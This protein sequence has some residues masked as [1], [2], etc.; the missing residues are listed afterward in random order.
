M[1]ICVLFLVF[2][3]C[4][5]AKSDPVNNIVDGHVGHIGEVLDYAHNNIVQT[6]DVMFLEGELKSCQMALID[7]KEAYSSVKE[8]YEAKISY[9][10]LMSSG[11]ILMMI[12]V[13]GIWIKRWIR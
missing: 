8:K 4:G 6:A 7:V 13:I 12:M 9:W 11:L 5:C 10:K 1:R 2:L 3:L